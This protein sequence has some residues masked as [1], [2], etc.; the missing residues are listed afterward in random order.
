MQSKPFSRDQD[1]FTLSIHSIHPIKSLK[2]PTSVKG[3]HKV[4][5]K[6]Y[7]KVSAIN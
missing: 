7:N 5:A 1:I 6:E 2:V 4:N 3:Y